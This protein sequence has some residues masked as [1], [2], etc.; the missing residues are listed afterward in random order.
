MEQRT[1]ELVEDVRAGAPVRLD[2]AKLHLCRYYE[3]Q[4]HKF[5]TRT[6]G[7]LNEPPSIW[8]SIDD[9]KDT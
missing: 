7:G 1:E 5:Q 4:Q 2:G 8:K 6:I 9:R 3:T